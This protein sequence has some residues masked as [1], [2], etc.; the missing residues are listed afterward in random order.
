[1]PLP[2]GHSL[3][4]YAAYDSFAKESKLTSWKMILLVVFVANLPDFDF[5]PG[6]LFGDPHMFHRHLSHSLGAAVVV[7]AML[8]GFFQLRQ[9]GS[10][11]QC[12]LMFFTVYYS[13]VLLDFFGVDNT[14]P[15]GVPMLWP[16]SDQHFLSPFSLFMAVK[17][18][19]SSGDFLQSLFVAHNLWTLVWEFT[20]LLPFVA[21]I[22]L[23]KRRKV[24]W[25]AMMRQ[26]GEVTNSN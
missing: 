10:F 12:F 18:S 11:K 17:K 6:L 14:D 20:V 7:G 9:M 22:R 24:L 19:N 3:I 8:A 13:H 5:L 25:G 2:V 15:T 21:I 4:G 23:V 1:M 26:A 16:F